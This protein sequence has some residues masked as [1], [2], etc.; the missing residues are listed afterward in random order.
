M[1]TEI[2]INNMKLTTELKS[3]IKVKELIL[4]IKKLLKFNNNTN[5]K[6]L[7]NN[8][9]LLNDEEIISPN[10]KTEKYKRMFLI[11]SIEEKPLIKNEGE[12]NEN[13]EKI[14]MKV[15]NAKT[16]MK[17]GKDQAGNIRQR[18]GMNNEED[19]FSR[20]MNILQ[21][22]ENNQLIVNDNDF[23]G[24]IGI[25][26]RN[27]EEVNEDYVKQLHEMGF[28]EDRARQALINS[29]NNIN[30]AT[31]ILLGETGE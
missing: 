1:K 3:D 14:I 23:G 2:L 29:R 12:T 18:M 15:T 16:A 31:E 10:L 26:R 19:P 30:R 25:E 24:R 22:L 11:E 9:V 8:Q 7:D 28:P 13:M 27:N 5:F 6:L 17:L 20:L 21:L 4:E